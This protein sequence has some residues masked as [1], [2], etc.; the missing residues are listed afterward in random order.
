M[1]FIKGTCDLDLDN[2]IA[3]FIDLNK[4][5]VLIT[6]QT[7]SYACNHPSAKGDVFCFK[8]SDN[9]PAHFTGDLYNC[10]C[11]GNEPLKIETIK[12]LED[13]LSEYYF[14]VDISKRNEE[15]WIY[16]TRKYYENAEECPCILT[17][18]NSD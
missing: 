18:A 4:D 13:E 8:I 3:A 2:G 10:W 14:K 12:F 6:N 1:S 7:G 16:G 17:W 11:D 5:G 9:I 15:A